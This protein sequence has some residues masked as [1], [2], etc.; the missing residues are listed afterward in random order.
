MIEL[1][2]AASGNKVCIVDHN[3]ITF[4]E[5]KREK[6]NCQVM[7]GRHNNGGWFVIETYEE[8]KAKIIAANA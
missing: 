2:V 4:A 7:D 6:A 1:T 3:S 8:V 5:N